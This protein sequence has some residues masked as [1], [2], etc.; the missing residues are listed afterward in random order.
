MGKLDNFDFSKIKAYAIPLAIIL[1]VVLLVPIFFVPQITR[2]REMNL[3]LKK[4]QQRLAIL[5]QKIVDLGKINENEESLQLLEAEKIVPSD[6][7]V[8]YLLMG[9]NRIANEAGLFVSEMELNPGKVATES[10]KA[11]TASASK[12]VTEGSQANKLP[13]DKVVFRLQ[14]KGDLQKFKNFLATLEKSKRLLGI[15]SIKAEVNGDT[16]T[17]NLNIYTPFKTLE[18]SGDIVAEPLPVFTSRHQS[19]F[20]MLAGFTDYME[21]VINEGTTGNK[22]PFK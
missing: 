4:S 17:Y 5:K 11:A 16:Y 2:F 8:P 20:N 12:S 7:K 6:K 18:S 19:I 1:A 15:D 3:E 22:D 9:V 21:E 14:L 13:K 10:A